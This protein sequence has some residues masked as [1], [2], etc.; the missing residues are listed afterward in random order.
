ME[1]NRYLNIRK[2]FPEIVTSVHF[3][4]LFLFVGFTLI[5]IL[6]YSSE[7]FGISL[8]YLYILLISL[9]GFW[10]G[11][12]GGIIAAALSTIIFI[13]EV[14]IYPNFPGRELVI[15]GAPFRL[16]VYFLSGII[17]G[18]FSKLQKRL[19]HKIEYLAYHDRLT[20]CV[21]YTW[22][23]DFLEKE[24]ARSRRFI[25]EFSIIL[26]DIDHFKKINDTY[27]HLVGN[28][29][30][31]AFANIIK[32]N[33]RN[34]DIVGR[35][36]GEE[37]LIIFPELGSDEALEVLKR[38]RE[39]LSEAKITSSRLREKAD[40]KLQFSAGIS[41]FPYNANNIKELIQVA[42][43]A[44]YQAKQRG[45]DRIIIER[46]RCARLRPLKDIKVEM[47]RL[48][49]REKL[50]IQKIENISERGMLLLLSSDIPE[51]ELLCRISV[52]GEEF[53]PEFACRVVHKSG[54]K[55]G[56]YHVGV[57]F[58]NIPTYTR[59]KLLHF[60]HPAET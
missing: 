9:S 4:L 34:M 43:D 8:G 40:I 57:Y 35:Y 16:I 7:A 49:D 60:A 48:S 20:G 45:R 10:F 33:V 50:R 56:L 54:L 22:I 3:Y 41:S 13:A 25:K 31:A 29:V 18:Y 37:F 26:I 51:G 46:R 17:I 24:I 2:K 44:L 23:I 53:P 15:I 6:R 38:I 30:L 58:V 59:G 5:S 42:D 14:E 21:N 32:N 55:G 28:D 27:G 39:R 19:S 12:K 47:A 52:S 36:G 1:K 11:V